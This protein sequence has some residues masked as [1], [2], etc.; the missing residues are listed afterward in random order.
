MEQ[1]PYSL[2]GVDLAVFADVWMYSRVNPYVGSYQNL[3][4]WIN[5][6]KT[7]VVRS[8]K[9]LADRGLVEVIN[10]NAHKTSFRAKAIPGYPLPICRFTIVGETDNNE[11]FVVKKVQAMFQNESRL[12]QNGPRLDQNGPSQYN[13]YNNNSSIYY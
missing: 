1:A 13:I 5:I 10:I 9:Y 7:T 3:A 4:D 8:V 2:S 6:P 12:D 11:A